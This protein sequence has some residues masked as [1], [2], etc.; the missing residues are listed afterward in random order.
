MAADPQQS[1]AADAMAHLAPGPLISIT[2]GALRVTIA[3][4]A[5]GRIA[6][7]QHDGVEHLVGYSEA[8]AAMIAWGCYPMVPW[9]GR[10]RHGR[11]R[12]RDQEYQLPLNLHPHSIHG[13][14]FAMPWRVDRHESSLAELSLAMPEDRRWPFGG[15]AHQRIAAT[16]HRLEMTLSVRA[17]RVPM[18]AALGWH[19]WFRK[20][21]Q[22]EFIPSH[23]YP[24]DDE[25][26]A[27][28]PLADPPPGPWDDCFINH[29][30]VALHIAGQKLHLRS[31]CL[32]WVVYD[33][34]SFATCIEPQSGPADAFNL[35]PGE[36]LPGA[37]LQRRFVIE[38]M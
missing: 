16:H 19:P 23:I 9:V 22:L 34:T 28:L 3:A 15:T 6:Q 4:Q 27:T 32:H 33:A 36:L 2:H 17:G 21:E 20:P 7:I 12:F 26:I 8:T 25:G 1:P 11:F 10:I 13:L 31:D 30:T 29:E 24:R 37:T 5:G 35:E 18:P 14:G 38:W